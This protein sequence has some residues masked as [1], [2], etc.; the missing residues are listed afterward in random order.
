MDIEGLNA[1]DVA[2]GELGDCWFISALS[3]LAANNQNFILS[4]MNPLMLEK[5]DTGQPLT[6]EIWK[7]LDDSLYSP[8]FHYYATKGMYIIRFMKNYKWH[9]VIMDDKIPCREDKMPI[10]AKDKHLKEFW[11]SLIEKAYAKLHANYDNLTSGFIHEG[12]TDLSEVAGL[13]IPDRAEHHLL[14]LFGNK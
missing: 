12:L 6:K 8:L 13:S 5:I 10:Y 7:N 14:L 1:G 2:Q 4:N 3:A 11:V 9:Y